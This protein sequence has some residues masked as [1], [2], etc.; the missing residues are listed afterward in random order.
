[1]ALKDYYPWTRYGYARGAEPVVYVANIRR[2][3]NRIKKEY[4]QLDEAA[5]P[6]RLEQLPDIDVPVFPGL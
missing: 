1:L 3:Y 5:E 6:E 4:P 2:F